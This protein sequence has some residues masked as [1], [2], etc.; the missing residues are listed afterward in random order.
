[1]Q[2]FR[3][4]KYFITF[5]LLICSLQLSAQRVADIP[6]LEMAEIGAPGKLVATLWTKSKK[7]NISEDQVCKDAIEV[8]VF[9]GVDPNKERRMLGRDALVSP[10]ADINGAYWNAFFDSK[11]Y[12]NYCRVGIEG[13]VEQGNIL[14]I[15]GGYVIGKLV[16]IDYN[17]LRQKLENDKIIKKMYE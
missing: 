7:N 17:M 13:Y 4:V 15:K 8:V 12:M 16:V 9:K 5:A 2:E 11:E 6:Y 3:L 14:K 1:M 10:N